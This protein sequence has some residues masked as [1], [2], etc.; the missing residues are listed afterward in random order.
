[1][2]RQCK[3]AERRV[4]GL[5]E[6]VARTM[7]SLSDIE[8]T[9]LPSLDE[10]T[11]AFGQVLAAV[12][13]HGLTDASARIARH[14]GYHVGRWLYM[15]DAAD[16]YETDLKRGRHNP[17]ARLYAQARLTPEVKE[18][19]ENAMVVEL[20]HARD[21]LDLITIDEQACGRELSPLLYH[22]LEEA[23]PMKTHAVLFPSPKRRKKESISHGRSL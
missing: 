15:L 19:L 17:L 4:P 6:A 22:I 20:S 23:L 16:D 10:P 14:I 2:R 8:A 9:A 12:M 18:Q 7:S 1:M 11:A 5:S 21:A 13:A 3:R